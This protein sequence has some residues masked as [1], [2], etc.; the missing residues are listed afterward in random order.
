M[1]RATISLLFIIG[2]LFL[3]AQG[4]YLDSLLQQ[5]ADSNAFSNSEWYW[6]MLVLDEDNQLVEIPG[7][8]HVIVYDE[9]K[10]HRTGTMLKGDQK[11]YFSYKNIIDANADSLLIKLKGDHPLFE[12]ANSTISQFTPSTWRFHERQR[13]IAHGLFFGILIV[14]ALYNLM[15]YMAVKD[16]SYLW[17][18][19][20]IIG[21]GLYMAFY[22]G[23][24]FEHF[25]PDRPHWNAYFFALIIPLTNISRILFTK[26]YLHTSE[27]VPR[28]NTF[29]TVILILYLTPIIMWL[30]SWLEIKDWLVETNYVIG[31]LG[32]ITMTAIT[33]TSIIVYK[34]GYKPALWFLV[35]FALFNIG[36]I[37]FIFRELN[38]LPDN[39]LTRYIVQIGAVAQVVLFSLGLSDRLNRTRK[40]LALETIEK[41]KIAREKEMEKKL[42]AEKQK[43]ELERQVKERTKELEETLSQL[44]ISESELRELNQVKSK[45]FS[46]ISH[47]LKSPLTTVDSYLNLFIN[48][49]N[50]LTPEEISELSDKTRFSLQNLILLMDNLLLWSRLQQESLTFNPTKVDLRKAIDKSLKLFTLSLEQKKIRIE[51]ESGVDDA[52]VHADKDMLEFVVRNLIHNSIKFTPKN[53][54]I[55]ITAENNEGYSRISIIDTGIGMTKDMIRQILDREE[56]FT[57]VG[58]EQEK[59]SGIGLLMC[60][61]FIE[62]NDGTLEISTDKGTTVTFSLPEHT[63]H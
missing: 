38:Y 40:M 52:M 46:I 14:M 8:S 55:K 33:L 45:L 51:I 9:D 39:F 57:R 16:Q 36:G 20:S 15:I 3:K 10:I 62:K 35:A 23:F 5:P 59:G 43:D 17:Y 54:R 29:F 41:E 48:H 26:T 28:W 32:A 11:S 21:F 60:K 63:P 7:W 1:R 2:V 50:K 53:G 24:S 44:K 18:V 22:Y 58:T 13:L 19:L 34:R 12:L 27:Y 30:I 42:L 25:W 49:Y 47:E 37:L 4:L 61:D 56:S 31:L 6:T